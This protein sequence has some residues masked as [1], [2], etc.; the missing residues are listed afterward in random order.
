LG[1]GKPLTQKM[2]QVMMRRVANRANV[3]AGVH[4]LRQTFCSHLAVGGAPNGY[5][6][7]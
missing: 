7:G 6:P 5:R 3:K 1:H 4:N 2:I